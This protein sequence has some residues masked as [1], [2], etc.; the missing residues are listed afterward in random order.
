MFEFARRLQ[1][2]PPRSAAQSLQA[3]GQELAGRGLSGVHEVLGKVVDARLLERTAKGSASRRR[4]FDVATAFEAFLWQALSGQASCQAALAQVQAARAARGEEPPANATGAFCRARAGLPL[5]RLQAIAQALGACTQKAVVPGGASTG[6]ALKVLDVT[7][8]QVQ[9]SA[10]NL[11]RWDYASGQRAGCGTPVMGLAAL[12]C[13][14][15]GAWLGHAA[16]TWKAHDL[17]VGLPLVEAHVHAGD[18]L[19]GDRA[20]CAWWLLAR[21]QEKGADALFRLH[22]SRRLNFGQ[23]VPLGRGDRLQGWPKPPRPAGCALSAEAYA[24]LPADL[25]VR[26][27]RVRVQARG[28]R[29]RQILLATTLDDAQA[30]PPEA[31]A[32]LYA[33]RWQAELCLDD[34]KT[35]LG[36]AY[37]RCKSPRI[38]ERALWVFASAYNLVRLMMGKAAGQEALRLSFKASTHV[39]V[40]W[41]GALAGAGALGWAGSMTW[42]E[43]L[44]SVLE[45]NVIPLRP[46]RHEP[47][48]VKRRPKT[49][50][51]LTR[52][53]A[54][55]RVSP[56]H[57]RTSTT[58]R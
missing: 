26:V 1:G 29:T 54:Q 45:H 48:A 32:A 8:I 24:A 35:S 42:W 43:R 21:L 50:Q 55:M 18:I 37:L 15:S 28:Q 47:R 40:A 3:R 9:D 51:L 38:V 58:S 2:R 20:F 17:S 57:G 27:V 34:L 31:L 53:R 7:G 6:R 36:M 13:A 23:G 25:F 52:P 22:Q 33:R 16:G 19:L 12:F 56:H 5:G 4:V 11:A 44:L 49:Y 30:W 14:H 39:L 46:G 10:A 41:T